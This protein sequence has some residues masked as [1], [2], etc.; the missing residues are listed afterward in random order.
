M[1]YADGKAKFLMEKGRLYRLKY[2]PSKANCPNSRRL[3]GRVFLALA[4]EF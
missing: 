1:Y 2:C 3:K 4:F